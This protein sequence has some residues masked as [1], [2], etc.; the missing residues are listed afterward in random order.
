MLLS[1]ISGS[2]WNDVAK[3]NIDKTILV[4]FLLAINILNAF[5]T[6]H[7]NINKLPIVLSL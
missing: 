6:F 4:N 3:L 5:C 2:Y 7:I 1:Y